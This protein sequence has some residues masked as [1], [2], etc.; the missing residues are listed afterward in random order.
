MARLRAEQEGDKAGALAQVTRQLEAEMQEKLQRR[1]TVALRGPPSATE[2]QDA[3]V[4]TDAVEERAATKRATTTA[5]ADKEPAAVEEEAEA[6]AKAEAGEGSRP[7]GLPKAV[8]TSLGK[9]TFGKKTI[10]TMPLVACRR[11]AAT[12]LAAKIQFDASDDDENRTRQAR[13]GARPTSHTLARP[14]LASPDLASPPLTSADL[15]LSF[16]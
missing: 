14:R 12:L 16:A 8:W 9:I 4:Q 6:E 3:A 2:T 10:P 7:Q 13:P 1:A 11:L 15:A 5:L